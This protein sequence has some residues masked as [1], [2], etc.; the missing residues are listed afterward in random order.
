MED[1]ILS[2]MY[3]EDTVWFHDGQLGR[4]DR[5]TSPI[6]SSHNVTPWFSMWSISTNIITVLANFFGIQILILSKNIGRNRGNTTR[7]CH[8]L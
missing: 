7:L 4:N 8:R 6:L 2:Y 3:L 1:F 5:N